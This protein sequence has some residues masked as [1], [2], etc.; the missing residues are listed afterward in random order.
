MKFHQMRVAEHYYQFQVQ[1]INFRLIYT[2]E[3]Q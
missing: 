1:D 3:F 2:F